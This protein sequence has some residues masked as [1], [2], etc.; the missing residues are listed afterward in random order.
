MK[1]AKIELNLKDLGRVHTKAHFRRLFPYLE[2]EYRK[3]LFSEIKSKEV[4]AELFPNEEFDAEKL[5]RL[6]LYQ[7]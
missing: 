1:K 5:R 7:N 2:N 4:F 6:Y 3:I